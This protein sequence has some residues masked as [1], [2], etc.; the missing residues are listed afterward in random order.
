[1][2]SIQGFV[3]LNVQTN[4]S[5]FGFNPFTKHKRFSY[6]SVDIKEARVAYHDRFASHLDL[7][8]RMR[9]DLTD[10]V[11][12]GMTLGPSGAYYFPKLSHAEYRIPA[13]TD[14]VV[15]AVGAGDAYFSL[16][17]ALV[18]VGSPEILVP[19]LGN[20]FA[21]LKTKIIGNKSAVSRAQ[22]IKAAT[23]LLK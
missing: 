1:L 14:T 9:N 12:L 16:T 13:F 2:Q 19:F 15:D 10:N 11:A 20:V 6:L 22:L 5:N 21:G 3:G 18:Q 23:S 17:S 8:R 4:S 7:L